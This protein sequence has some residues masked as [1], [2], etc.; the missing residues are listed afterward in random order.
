MLQGN[1]TVPM[2]TAVGQG[3]RLLATVWTGKWGVWLTFAPDIS[4]LQ[5][6]QRSHE[7]IN[8]SSRPL[9]GY[10]IILTLQWTY[11]GLL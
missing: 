10:T 9:W 5:D 3:R 11:K 8:V 6:G 4:T 1:Q 2:P 7:L